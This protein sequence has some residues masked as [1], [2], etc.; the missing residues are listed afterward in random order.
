MKRLILLLLCF[1]FPISVCAQAVDVESVIANNVSSLVK[2]RKVPG[3]AVALIYRG[4]PYSYHY[5]YSDKRK[6][7]PITGDTLFEIASITKVFTTLLIAQQVKENKL[8]LDEKV[9]NYLPDPLRQ[10]I[11]FREISI[12]NL[13]TH[14]AS[15]PSKLPDFI[16]T[17]PEALL[18]LAHWQPLDPIGSR[19]HY[20]NISIGLLGVVLENQ[21]GTPY[22]RLV[23][24]KILEPLGMNSTYANLDAQNAVYLAQGYNPWS[25]PVGLN[26][27]GIFPASYVL[28]SSSD[29]MML[30]LKAT[31]NLPGTP[32]DIADAM[33]LTQTAFFN[34]RDKQQGLGWEIHSLNAKKLLA[35]QSY[36]EYGK[37]KSKMLPSAKI[38][39]D[40]NKLLDKTGTSYG[41]RAYIAIIPEQQTGIV[42][43]MNR[44]NSDLEIVTVGRKILLT[45]LRK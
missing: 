44:K 35:K 12:K 32:P 3:I 7:T 24:E 31:L 16:T 1:L 39:F 21:T 14:T 19:W 6:K 23:K 11:P 25:R 41:F 38:V 27:D 5:G 13:A 10:S 17:I 26:T 15:M 20:S 33:K 8:L 30:F 18:Y 34:L 9:A 2:K 37:Q 40:G 22:E 29:D 45:L 28:K 36:R 42:I 43:L 4:E